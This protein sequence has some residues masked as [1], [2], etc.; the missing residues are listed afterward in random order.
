MAVYSGNLLLSLDGRIKICDMGVAEV[1]E[2]GDDDWFTLS[3]GTPK[4]QPPEIV[5]GLNK[6]FRLSLELVHNPITAFPSFQ[7]STS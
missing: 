1:L 4:F 7:G 6:R 5:S 2:E 3:Q